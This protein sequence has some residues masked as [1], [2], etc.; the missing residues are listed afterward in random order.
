MNRTWV[1]VGITIAVLA[2]AAG[3]AFA[4]A[5]AFAPARAEAPVEAIST[6]PSAPATEV[7]PSAFPNSPLHTSIPGCVCHSD[8]PKLVEEHAQYRMSECFGCHNGDVPTGQE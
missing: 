6:Q 3:V 1:I 5:G 4:G 2:T 7:A 8:N